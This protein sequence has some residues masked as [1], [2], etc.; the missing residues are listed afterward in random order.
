MK[1]VVINNRI[2]G[3][4]R[5]VREIWIVYNKDGDEKAI[6]IRQCRSIPDLFKPI[7]NLSTYISFNTYLLKAINS[8][9]FINNV[10]S[11]VSLNITTDSIIH[12]DINEV[13]FDIYDLLVSAKNFSKTLAVTLSTSHRLMSYSEPPNYIDDSLKHCEEIDWIIDKLNLKKS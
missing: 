3:R 10:V 1:K 9:A 4:I 11:D 12:T 8:V 7:S 6:C 2:E 5:L 13:S